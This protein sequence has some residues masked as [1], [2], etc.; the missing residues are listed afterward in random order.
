MLHSTEYTLKAHQLPTL[1]CT[2]I[3][4]ASHWRVSDSSP[5]AY[6]RERTCKLDIGAFLHCKELEDL[7]RALGLWYC[8][9]WEMGEN[10]KVKADSTTE[11][12][13]RRCS[14]N[15]R[16]VILFGVVRNRRASRENCRERLGDGVM[17]TVSHRNCILQVTLIEI[18]TF[19]QGRKWEFVFTLQSHFVDFSQ[20]H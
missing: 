4:F 20:D 7:H 11:K 9:C 6:L 12:C 16:N 1:H 14:W 3:G 8:E 10:E 19:L 2:V 18:E 13:F 17:K 5:S 15:R